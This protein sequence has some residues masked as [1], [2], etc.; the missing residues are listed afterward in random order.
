MT[1]IQDTIEFME[2]S[3]RDRIGD[4]RIDTFFYG[5]NKFWTDILF[6]YK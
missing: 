2:P 3:Q 1:R 6:F 5:W 4:N